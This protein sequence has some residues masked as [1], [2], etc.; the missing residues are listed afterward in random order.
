MI[1]LVP[2]IVN[3]ELID[4]MQIRLS[5]LRRGKPHPNHTNITVVLDLANDLPG[6]FYMILRQ[7]RHNIRRFMNLDNK[8][9]HDAIKQQI[10]VLGV[11][12]I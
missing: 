12:S 8:S 6:Y 4:E 2:N 3:V 5:T 9:L 10:Y 11:Y 1:E 7:G